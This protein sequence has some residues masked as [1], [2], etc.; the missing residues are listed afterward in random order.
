MEPNRKVLEREAEKSR[1]AS[2]QDLNPLPTLRRAK[3]QSS[4]FATLKLIDD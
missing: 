1:A 3:M 4:K 2:R